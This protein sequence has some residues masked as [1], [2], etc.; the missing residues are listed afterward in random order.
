MGRAVNGPRLCHRG[1]PV[2]TRRRAPDAAALRGRGYQQAAGIC[3]SADMTATACDE[4]EG[5]AIETVRKAT[6]TRSSS[7]PRD[8]RPCAAQARAPA[9]V[10]E[11]WLAGNA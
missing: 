2:E 3:R 7:I 9:R 11:E 1:A 4:M 8:R 10:R 6:F 5:D